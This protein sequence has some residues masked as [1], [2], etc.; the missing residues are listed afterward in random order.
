[1]PPLA[2]RALALLGHVA[3]ALLVTAPTVLTLPWRLAGDPD[4]DVWNHAWGP[5]WWWTALSSGQLP[6]RTD[7][8]VHPLGG[9]LWFI[10]PVLAGAGAPL[11]P[12][13]GVAG[14]YNVV[15][16]GYVAFS[17]WAAGRLAASLGAEPWGRWVASAAFAASAWMVCE[18]HNGI[19]EAAD[20][21][22]VALALAWTEDAAR[23]SSGRRWARAGLGVGLAAVAS[24]YLGLGAGLYALVRGLPALRHAWLG[25]LVAVLVAAPPALLLR[26][27]LHAEDA[28]IKHPESMN[29][30]L[31]LHNA[32]DT[33]LAPLGFRSVDLSAEGFEHSMYLG[34]VA[35][36]LAA[37]G[38]WTLR[39]EGGRWRGS[40]PWV[41]A[42]G[43]A[44][45]VFALGPYLYW[46]DG[47]AAP[48]GQRLRLPWW[49]LQQLA[50]GLAVTH[51]L[52]LAVPALAAVAGLAGV[53]ASRLA[54]GPRALGLVFLVLVDG[55]VR[56]GG[57][58][59]L[60][61]AD[62]RAPRAVAALAKADDEPAAKWAILDL[63]TDV[64]ATMATSRYLVWQTAHGRAIPYGPD[65]RASTSPLIHESA[66]RT[67]AG[68]S[69]RRGD[70]ARR[71][72]LGGPADRA[73][74][75][76]LRDHGIRWVAVHHFLD[77]EAGERLEALIA[78]ELGAG[79]RT[80][81]TTVWDLG[82]PP[83]ADRRR[84]LPRP[85]GAQPGP[86]PDPQ[87]GGA[88]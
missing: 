47:W 79:T 34:L 87:G 1:M 38:A 45:A 43:V 11:V 17:S 12:L 70:E 64:G 73:A 59:P 46:G 16:I 15:V 85:R 4:V 24:P 55:L 18:L 58:W 41:A 72:G 3:L 5:W 25:G 10:D 21:G 35:L 82:E 77:P 2:R 28:I 81:G 27:Q 60:E 50:P 40:G 42:A 44:T 32:V 39:R 13:L 86:G 52:R 7:L 74:T 30:Q 6:W 78:A 48:G 23:A 14:A 65:A 68:A 37:L 53:G 33:F 69:G 9:V 20:I 67:L 19:T 84:G 8:L 88:P 51:P 61:T 49:A 22:F 80:D 75:R 62:A 76:S 63:P 71:L 57:P 31:A 56:S 54:P 26:A 29:D 66:F 36:G 83:P